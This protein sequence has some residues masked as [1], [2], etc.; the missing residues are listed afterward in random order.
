MKTCKLKRVAQ[1]AAFASGIMLALASSRAEAGGMYAVTAIGPGQPSGISD[2]GQVVLWTSIYKDGVVTPLPIAPPSMGIR[3]T[4]SVISPNG[5]VAY[6]SGW[7]GE[8]HILRDSGDF[9]AAG[10][11]FHSSATDDTFGSAISQP[12]AINDAG[13]VV[14]SARTYGWKSQAYLATPGPDGTYHP[15]SLGANGG[16][17][18][19]ATAI[20]NAGTVA[21]WTDIPG[22]WKNQAFVGRSQETIGTL[23]GQNSMATSI[24]DRDQVVGWSNIKTD[25]SPP[26]NPNSYFTPEPTHAFFY[27][28]GKMS[29]LGILPGY[30]DSAATAINA[31]GQIVG[32]LSN[33]ADSVITDSNSIVSSPEHAAFWEPGATV[34]T[35]LND[36]L[37]PG[38]G[39]V[40]Q[41]ATGI[42][43]SGQIAGYGTLDGQQ[44]AF[45]LR[46]VAVPEPASFAVFGLIAAAG[47]LARQRARGRVRA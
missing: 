22:Q 13:V 37:A 20:N 6:N 19:S 44:Q 24:N 35:D 42:N 29:D 36:L 46:P 7:P 25:W 32:H 45:L 11:P 3:L 38:S 41:A 16:T 26:T 4:A 27:Q 28:D 8:S 30:E 12:N 18:S 23:G 14:G 31:M 21:G 2:A 1:H 9:V 10:P 17:I 40:L 5:T 34:P 33:T 15:V 47:L 43:A 39:W